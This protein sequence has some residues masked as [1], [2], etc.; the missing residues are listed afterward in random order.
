[1]TCLYRSSV[2]T[3]MAAWLTTYREYGAIMIT[4]YSHYVFTQAGINVATGERYKHVID[5]MILFAKGAYGE[6]SGYPWMDQNLKDKLLGMPRARELKELAAREKRDI[7]LQEIREKLGGPGISDEEF[8]LRYIMKGEQE[9]EA[10]R[11]AGPPRQYFSTAMP[12]LTLIQELGKQT[13]VRYVRVRRGSD[14]LLIQNQ[15]SG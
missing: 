9:I 13:S 8:L 12:L 15:S 10:M 3:L 7:P 5:D 2:A 1:M 11:A 4:P 14:S 6:D